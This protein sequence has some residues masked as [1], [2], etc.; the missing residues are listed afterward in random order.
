MACRDVIE[1]GEDLPRNLPM[2]HCPGKAGVIQ[3]TLGTTWHQELLGNT[4]FGVP[5][6]LDLTKQPDE[7][8]EEFLPIFTQCICTKS[9]LNLPFLM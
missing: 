1:K 4:H 7:F 8:Y 3:G 9:W 2:S 5:L 6:L